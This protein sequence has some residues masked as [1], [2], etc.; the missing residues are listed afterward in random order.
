LHLG[1]I[2][3]FLLDNRIVDIQFAVR[4]G[5]ELEIFKNFFHSLKTKHMKL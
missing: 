2:S 5:I 3:N 4:N 1:L